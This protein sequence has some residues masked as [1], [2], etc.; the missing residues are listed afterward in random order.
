MLFQVLDYL[1]VVVFATAGGIAASRKGLD[2]IAF[3]FFATFT[4]MGG[5]TLRDVLLDAPVFW[6]R[7]DG[8]LLVCLGT[9]IFMWFFA[10]IIEGFGKPLRWADAIGM[11]AYSV[12][13]AAKA[14]SLGTT[15]FVAVLMGVAT[16]TFGG[17]LR[18]VIAGEPSSIVKPEI[19]VSA[20]FVGAG[21]Y[22]VLMMADFNGWVAA[23]AGVT[24]SLILRGGAI[25]K[26]WSLPGYKPPVRRK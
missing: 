22:V 9:A 11:S 20:A 14:L 17:V 18:D 13:G 4:G 23:I 3:L 8:Y 12:M 15:A 7:A 21:A 25:E 24:L 6:I 1:G 19:Y 10:H 26:G 16:A 5:G 2:F